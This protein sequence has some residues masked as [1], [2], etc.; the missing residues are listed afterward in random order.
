MA[1]I[2]KTTTLIPVLSEKSYQ[3]SQQRNRFV[4][5]VPLSVNRNTVASAVESQFGVN[6]VTVNITRVKGKAKST[7]RKGGRPIAGKTNEYKKAYVLLAEGQSIPIFQVED[8]KAKADAKAQA[9]AKKRG[10][11]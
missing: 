3:L 8:D 9:K 1:D 2:F 10:S 6:V 11:K 5:K 7:N 4:F